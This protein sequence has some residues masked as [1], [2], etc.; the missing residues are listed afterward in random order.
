[1]LMFDFTKEKK[2]L[3]SFCYK[4]SDGKTWCDYIHAPDW[5][6]A[7][8]N[9]LEFQGFQ[10]GAVTDIIEEDTGRRVAMEEPPDC[11]AYL[12]AHPAARMS[13]DIFEN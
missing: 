3:F 11:P 4:T 10:C 9:V 7:L 6:T 5:Q 8:D 13:F 2:M 1:M 12:R